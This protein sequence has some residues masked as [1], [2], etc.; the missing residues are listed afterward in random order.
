VTCGYCR[1]SGE[2]EGGNFV[3]L[4]NVHDM[5][6]PECKPYKDR[7]DKEVKQ[8]RKFKNKCDICA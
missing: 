3:R 5:W 7:L 4:D 8:G 1:E 6:C 2:D